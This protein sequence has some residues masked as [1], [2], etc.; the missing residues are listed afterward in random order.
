MFEFQAL[1]EAFRRLG[2]ADAAEFL[3]IG[4]AVY[5]IMRFLRGTRGARLVR[6]FIVLLVSSTVV[7]YL[8]A[9]WLHLERI[10]FLY[11]R[12]VLAIF[13]IALVS[14]QPELR[15]ALMRLG[16][17]GWFADES[18]DTGHVIDEVVSA[19][20][21]LSKNKI[22]ALIAF[23]RATE[24][25]GLIESGCRLDAEV[26]ARLINTIFWPGSALHDMGVVISQGTIAAAGVQFPLTEATDLD[27]ALGS[28]HRAAVGLAEES[29]ALILVISEETGTISL[30][31]HG[32]MLRDL[33][34]DAL[35]D[36]LRSKLTRPAGLDGKSR[37]EPS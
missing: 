30:V 37:S 34:A 3:V 14:F 29:D 7:L 9:N 35:R 8:V 32:K 24:F 11:D 4:V 25:G 28:R 22:G 6:G 13:L 33:T 19:A 5:L 27:P 23:E 36:V 17:T 2:W 21:N 15:R 26:S 31:E 1:R 18:R 10:Q 16:A 20:A 12:F